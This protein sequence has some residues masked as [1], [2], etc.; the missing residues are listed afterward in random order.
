[1]GTE[2]RPAVLRNKYSIT[3]EFRNRGKHN[4]DRARDGPRIPTTEHSA[5]RA[6]R[7]LFGARAHGV[8]APTCTPAARPTGAA[9]DQS[10]ERAEAAAASLF[11]PRAEDA[12][13]A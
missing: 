13:G 2:Y 12:E 8:G 11:A 1:M 3:Y 9:V 4:P 6:T 7:R 5:V 10:A